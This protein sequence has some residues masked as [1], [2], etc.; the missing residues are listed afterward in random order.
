MPKSNKNLTFAQLRV[1]LFV[2]AGLVILGFL[3]LNATGEFNPFEEKLNLKARF[4]NAD[5]LRE[6]AEVQLA[7]VHI[8]KVTEVRFLSPDNPEDAKSEAGRSVA[9]MLD[10]RED[11]DLAT[12]TVTASIRLDRKLSPRAPITVFQHGLR[13]IGPQRINQPG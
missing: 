7:G 3:I 4:V 10:G 6:G 9:Q 1:G 5:G 8:G 11:L 12:G 13:H 2:L